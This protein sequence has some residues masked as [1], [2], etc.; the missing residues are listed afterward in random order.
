MNFQNN[1]SFQNNKKT[2][3]AK[4]DKSKKGEIDENLTSPL[5]SFYP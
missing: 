5:L 4:L 1:K 2:F 3:L